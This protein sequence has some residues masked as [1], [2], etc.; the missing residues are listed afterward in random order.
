MIGLR[1]SDVDS[2]SY[3]D[4]LCPA[5]SCQFQPTP[6]RTRL[7]PTAKMMP[8]WG[9]HLRNG[10]KCKV[11]AGGENKREWETA[12]ETPRWEKKMYQPLE[13]RFACS[14]LKTL[15][16]DIFWRSSAHVEIGAERR[17]EDKGALE[18]KCHLMVTAPPPPGPLS[19]GTESVGRGVKPSL[20]K[21]RWKVSF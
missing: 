14:P 13:Q 4:G 8:S 12:E 17:S 18:R 9:K 7:S 10:R 21:G 19:A 5:G 6:C 20:G 3:R 15:Q 2:R 16:V 1:C 11:E